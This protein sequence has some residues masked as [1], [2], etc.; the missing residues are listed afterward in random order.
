L[1]GRESLLRNVWGGIQDGEDGDDDRRGREDGIGMMMMCDGRKNALRW[2]V[3]DRGCCTEKT[4]FWKK[5]H[6]LFP[7]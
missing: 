7:E 2:N 6:I 1:G 3:Y 4:A 5:L